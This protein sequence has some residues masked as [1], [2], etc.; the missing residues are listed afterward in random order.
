MNQLQKVEDVLLYHAPMSDAAA[1][2]KWDEAL[3]IVREMMKQEPVAWMFREAG[4]GWELTFH[5]EE[6]DALG[7]HIK[8]PLVYASAP[9]APQPREWVGLTDEEINE[10]GVECAVV[11][12]GF[13]SEAHIEFANAISDALRLKNGG[14]K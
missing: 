14:V 4:C 8:L 10:I 3:A 6:A 1:K 11:G 9:A 7:A 12:E 2:R 13:W 5:E